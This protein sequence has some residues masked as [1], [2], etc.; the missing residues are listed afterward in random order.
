MKLHA[1]QGKKALAPVFKQ[2]FT[3][4]ELCSLWSQYVAL[5]CISTW[6]TPP[7]Q[8]HLYIVDRR[9]VFDTHLSLVVSHT[10]HSPCLLPSLKAVVQSRDICNQS[11]APLLAARLPSFLEQVAIWLAWPPTACTMGQRIKPIQPKKASECGNG[12]GRE[13]GA[14]A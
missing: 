6:N 12:I 13:G 10:T 3:R 7:R 11:M 4:K 8:Q 5:L 1:I 14:G 2:I 9:A